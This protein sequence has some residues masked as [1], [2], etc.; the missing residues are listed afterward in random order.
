[1]LPGKKYK[2]EDILK[3]LRKRYWVV[4]VPWVLAAAATAAV[5]RRLPDMYRS[6]ALIQVVP[7]QV[8]ESIVRSVS[9]GNFLDRLS[10]TTQTILSRTRLERV[11]NEFNLYQEERKRLI[12]EEVVENMRNDIKVTPQKGDTFRIEYVGRSPVTVMKVTEKLAS[13]FRDESQVE[14]ERRAEGT[15]SFVEAQVEEKKQQLKAVEDRVTEYQIKHAG[16]MPEQAQGNMQ[17]IQTINQS[18]NMLAANI[19]NDQAQI[20]TLEGNIQILEQMGEVP[21][22]LPQAGADPAT[23]GTAAQRLALAKQMIADNQIRGMIDTH[24]DMRRLQALVAQLTKEVNDEALKNPVG[25]GV[26]LS[27]EEQNRQ[28][29]LTAWREEIALI[30]D[31]IAKNQEQQKIL[32]QK[33]AGYQAKIDAVPFRTAEFKE[34]TREYDTL[35]GIYRDFLSKRETSAASVNLERRQIGEQFNLLDQAR[36]P[37]KP[38]SPDRSYINMF[39]F[40]GG[41][42]FGLALVALL[43]YRDSTFRTD[44]EVSSVLSLPV[45]AVVPLMR[46][47]AEKR[48]AFRRKLI[49]NVGLGSTVMVGLAV[50][51]YAIVR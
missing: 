9:N 30:K 15:N 12:M 44:H 3:I 6:T 42:A 45:L 37:E 13:Y 35:S 31:R 28:A 8:P 14:G 36:L 41:L 18:R 7:P 34:M 39:G 40:L 17:A 48:S 22:A 23:N 50:L 19:A 32:E 29:R 5:A 16:E 27:K 21:V 11:I 51:A 46:S 4:L 47:A 33:Q 38:F 2:P 1:M 10:A 49:L 43:E 24:P 20:R 25:A 26:G